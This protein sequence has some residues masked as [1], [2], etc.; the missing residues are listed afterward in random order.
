M[1]GKLLGHI[2]EAQSLPREAQEPPKSSQNGAKNVKKVMLKNKSFLD[3]ILEGF[4]CRFGKVFGSFFC[5]K[6]HDKCKEG[7]SAKTF[8][9]VILP[10]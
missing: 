2:L 9:I 7:V 10:R 8:K 1:I 6:M 3:S 4:G 5:P